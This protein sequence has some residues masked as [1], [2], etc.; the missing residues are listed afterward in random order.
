MIIA[1]AGQKG[2]SGKTTTALAIAAE[3]HDRGCRVLLVDADPQ[4]SLRTWAEVAA[5]AGHSAPTVV[6]MGASMYRADQLPTL[7]EGYDEVVI[8]CPP[9]HD[10]IQRA[11]L[12]VADL[13]VL[14]C[15]PSAMD[16]WALAEGLDLVTRARQLRPELQATILITRKVA[17]TSLGS[18]ARQTLA[19]C[20]LP[21]LSTEL[22]FRVAYQ[23]APAA[24][25]GV[26]QYDP[27]SAA[28]REVRKLVDEVQSIGEEGIHA[29]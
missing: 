6:A 14:P 26:A 9:R 18:G 7:A 22:G 12:M 19:G 15:G 29:A 28:A 4:G 25:L 5:E 13:V 11:A 20:G 21:V 1:L 8:D 10:D 17:R 24:G 2:G 3:W 23:E 16:A 27:K